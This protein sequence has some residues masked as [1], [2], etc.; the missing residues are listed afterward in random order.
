MRQSRF[1]EEQIIAVLAEQERGLKTAD[2]L[3]PTLIQALRN[4]SGLVSLL[5]K[6]LRGQVP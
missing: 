4:F 2:D 6:C 5:R 1:T 3:P